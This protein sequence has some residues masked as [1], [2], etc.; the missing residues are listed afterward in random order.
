MVSVTCISVASKHNL[1]ERLCL[2]DTEPPQALRDFVV[3]H[4]N[5]MNRMASAEDAS[6]KFLIYLLPAVRYRPT[7]AMTSNGSATN[8]PPIRH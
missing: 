1:T 8:P 2:L 4:S 3:T 6:F 5:Y 7:L